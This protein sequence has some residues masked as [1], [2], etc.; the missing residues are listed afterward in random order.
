ME[1]RYRKSYSNQELSVIKKQ[2]L[3]NK[4]NKNFIMF[5]NTFFAKRNKT[6]KVRKRK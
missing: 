5:N 6:C 3:K 4:T 1:R 2:I